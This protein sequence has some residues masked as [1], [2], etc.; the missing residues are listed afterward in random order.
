[1]S[2]KAIKIKKISKVMYAIMNIAM[3][4]L[5]MVIVGVALT[6]ILS[7]PVPASASLITEWGTFSFGSMAE[8]FDAI[9]VAIILR[10]GFMAA[11]LFMTSLIF[12]DISRDDHPFSRKHSDRLKIIA[13]LV[14]ALVLVVPPF[15]MLLTM[16]IAPDSHAGASINLSGLVYSA[17][18]YCLALIFEYG[19]ELQ[20]L[21]DETL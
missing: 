16:I 4:L 3:I 1:M 13:L 8:N 9:L 5:V 17:V 2:E 18:F 21:S 14:I 10:S 19:A 15:Q 7:L 6:L 11:I 20:Q 12:R